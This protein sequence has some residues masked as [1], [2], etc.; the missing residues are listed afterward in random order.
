MNDFPHALLEHLAAIAARDI[1]VFARSIHPRVRLVGSDGTVREGAEA[2]IE[3]HRAW[4]ADPQWSIE[5]A[6]L[7]LEHQG[8]CCWSLVRAR[9]EQAETSKTFLLFLLFVRENG[10]WLLV[11]D[12][13]T[14]LA[15]A[16]HV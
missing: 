8:E 5:F 11:Y 10:R 6:P 14:D 7:F 12:Q 2:A 15:E 9:F 3:A 1:D 16:I 13:G 4:F